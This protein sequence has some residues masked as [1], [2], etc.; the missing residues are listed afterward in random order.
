MSSEKSFKEK[1]D[2]LLVWWWDNKAAFITENIRVEFSSSMYEG[3]I[4]E[5]TYVVFQAKTFTEDL[6]DKIENINFRITGSDKAFYKDAEGNP[7]PGALWENDGDLHGVLVVSEEK[8]SQIISTGFATNA[9]EDIKFFISIH[10]SEDLKE[11]DKKSSIWIKEMA[12][13]VQEL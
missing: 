6:K 13:V 10:T 1:V 5:R 8:I 11:W 4:L 9:N 3:E 12:I 7:V 2:N